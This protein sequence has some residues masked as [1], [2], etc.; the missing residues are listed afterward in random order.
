M[1]E[2]EHLRS[3][4]RDAGHDQIV[5]D[6]T[7]IERQYDTLRAEL[8]DIEVRFAMKACPVDEVLACLADRGAGFDAA[9][10][11]EIRQALRTGVAPQRVHYG[12]TVKS[13]A[14]IAA[15]HQ[16]GITTFATD[17]AE[18]VRAVA[19]HAP[20]ARVYCRLTT[21]G[22]GAVWG[23]TGK[24][25][26]T[27][28]AA[29]LEEAR[30]LGLVPAGLSLHAGSQQ[31]TVAGWREALDG[32]ATAVLGLLKRGIHVDRLNLGGGL[33]AH[34]YLNRDGSPMTPP[35]AGIFAAI[36]DGVDR[37]RELAGDSLGFVIEPG[38]YL[39]ADHGV[40]RAHV[41]RLTKR[42]QPWLYLSCGRFN[43]LYEA[44]QL[45]YRLEFPT[46]RGGRTV[47]AVVAGPTCDSD[48]TFGGAAVPVPAALAS[49]DPVWIHSAGAYTVGYATQGFNG[50][51]PLPCV[52]VRAER[53]RSI[54]PGD[55]P[56][57]TALETEAYGGIGLSES[58]AVLESRARVSPS[59][60]FVLEVG[61]RVGGYLLALPYPRFQ[62]PDP[63][64]AEEAAHHSSNLH[65]HDIVVGGSLRGR[66]WARRMVRHLTNAARS[67]RFD[68]ISLV[69]V[70][71]TTG[72][73][74]AHGFRPQP[75]VAVPAGYGPGAVY[76]SR[77]ITANK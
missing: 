14:E 7:G 36:R 5:Y 50:F 48:D 54:R 22:T 58:R 63:A 1:S 59:T 29:V 40:I 51:A 77:S 21:S 55:W 19:R 75:G 56:G 60:S 18:D 64:R 76:M 20:G 52:A 45:R 35:T 37:L 23:L 70:G 66:G 65:L 39:V 44:D 32:L 61:G 15:A 24:F 8:P 4:L 46:R 33:P 43:G 31:M 69:A 71:G 68:R 42:P 57:I 28:P 2:P 67:S 38:R 73:W 12:N 26:A 9:S 74:S 53:L 49:G 72:F 47:P 13:D 41:A 17:S 30:R 34:G 27:D 11:G 25:G 6:L 3:A 10:P 16:H 62:F